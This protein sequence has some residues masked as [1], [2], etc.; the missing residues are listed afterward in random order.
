MENYVIYNPEKHSS[1]DVVQFNSEGL[2]V[3]CPICQSELLVITSKNLA[4]KYGRPQGF[5]CPNN[6]NHV[7]I[8]FILAEER[9]QFWERFEQRMKKNLED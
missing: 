7:W 1:K 3:L 5:F 6:N 9:N 2:T 8:K 4:A